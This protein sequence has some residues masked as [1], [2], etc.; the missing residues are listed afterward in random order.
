MYALA[1]LSNNDLCKE[2]KGVVLAL[3]G[4]AVLSFHVRRRA[5]NG[6]SPQ[7]D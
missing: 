7:G 3:R 4:G 5:L 1:A 2:A 6:H